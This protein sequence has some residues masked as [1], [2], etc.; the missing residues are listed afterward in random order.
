[1]AHCIRSTRSLGVIHRDI[2]GSNI[3]AT[4][5]GGVKLAD[6]GVAT[7]T[8]ALSDNAVVGS[9]YWMAPEVVDQSGATTASDIWSVGC[10][11]IELLEGK[12][13]YYFLEPMPALFRIVNDDCPPLP[14]S[15]SPIA[16]DFLLQCFQKDQNLRISAK[17]LLK[18][19]WM[20]SARKRLEEKEREQ[21]I[22]QGRRTP[23]GSNQSADQSG[24]TSSKA[25]NF[26][27]GTSRR[28]ES[29][30][31]PHQLPSN[32]S[33]QNLNYMPHRQHEELN[34]LRTR[35][36]SRGL[37]TNV[38]TGSANKSGLMPVSHFEDAAVLMNATVRGI[39]SSSVNRP[40]SNI[41]L[42]LS[43]SVFP[44]A[45][46]AT[47]PPAQKLAEVGVE[48]PQGDNWDD[49]FEG[50]ISTSKIAALDSEAHGNSN[51]SEGEMMITTTM[52]ILAC[53]PAKLSNKD[54]DTATI[55]PVG[56]VKKSAKPTQQSK[57]LL[58]SSL[59]LRITL[60]LLVRIKETRLRVNQRQKILHPK[61]ISVPG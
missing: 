26:P 15:A 16:R 22:A 19:P 3:L 8:G 40:T 54:D 9:P 58:S 25:G 55:K 12:P 7:R 18:H 60:T 35:K 6:F 32:Q 5:E 38:G 42:P 33:S 17:K 24:D 45:V 53:R 49:D 31:S 47:T 51:S 1:M 13:P 52:M 39:G 41:S 30:L 48:S 59:L 43:S 57:Q 29:P 14:E 46:M 50:T 36:T 21:A 10:V 37:F 61:D 4:K 11:V 34:P 27:E 28:R 23:A 20:L 44:V 56:L 2:K